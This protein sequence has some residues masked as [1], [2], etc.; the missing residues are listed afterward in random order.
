M[1]EISDFSPRKKR[2]SACVPQRAMVRLG[3]SRSSLANGARP[4]RVSRQAGTTP[5]R[6]ASN[7]GPK[8]S[9]FQAGSTVSAWRR[10]FLDKRPKL[11][12]AER[13]EFGRRIHD[14]NFSVA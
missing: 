7:L 12:Q 9:I 6:N 11:R 1:E 10:M 5:Q 3:M 8:L 4:A 14:L 2:H 13:T